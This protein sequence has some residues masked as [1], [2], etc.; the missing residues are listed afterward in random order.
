M[1]H[2]RHQL[3]PSVVAATRLPAPVFAQMGT[4]AARENLT[5]SAWLR[6]LVVREIRADLERL[7]TAAK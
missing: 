2:R 7:E 3:A 5:P 4:L 6:S 1:K